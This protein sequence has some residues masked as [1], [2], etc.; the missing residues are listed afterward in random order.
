V[1]GLSL[2][3]ETSPRECEKS[4]ADGALGAPGGDVRDEAHALLVDLCHYASRSRWN[5]ISRELLISRDV[6]RDDRSPSR[7]I[8]S[9]D[10]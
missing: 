4:R 8:R 7:R 1:G 10:V 2:E 3:T 5:N 9:Y 6:K